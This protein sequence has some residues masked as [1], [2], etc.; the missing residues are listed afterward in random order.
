MNDCEKWANELLM[1]Q[2]LGVANLKL[3]IIIPNPLNNQETDYVAQ[4]LDT[5][6]Q[7]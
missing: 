7:P 5:T 4:S 2:K 6:K 3:E 1:G